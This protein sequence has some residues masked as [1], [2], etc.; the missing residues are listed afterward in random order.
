LV[1]VE[2]L[3]VGKK[4]DGGAGVQKK[5]PALLVALPA[6]A[7]A[8]CAVSLPDPGALQSHQ[9]VTTVATPSITP[10][11]DAEAIAGK[12]LPLSAGDTLQA[13]VPVGISDG[14]KDA[15]EWKVERSNVQGESQY[16]KS[17][18]CTVVTRVRSNQGAL[19]VEGNEKASTAALFQYLDPSILPEYLRVETLP[20]GDGQG[21]K[22]KHQ[23]EV[24]ALEG[25]K[26]AGSRAT[27]IFARLFTKAGSSAYV[28][29]SCP[30]TGK[31]AE[32]KDD[33][34]SHLMLVPPTD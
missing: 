29:V 1:D 34:M 9:E 32:A 16:S 13:G 28:S 19:S 26:N 25:N 4:P 17:D 23:V 31:L 30:D 7:L 3:G 8:S 11:H 20:W 12:D 10:G 2:A 14:L 27:A 5:W 21:D 24:L 6:L 18:G 33:I 15:P 22:P